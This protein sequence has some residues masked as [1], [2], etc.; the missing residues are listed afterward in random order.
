MPNRVPTISKTLRIR[1]IGRS[2]LILL[3]IKKYNK[4]KKVKKQDAKSPAGD[5]SIANALPSLSKSEKHE[6]N[7]D[8]K[9]LKAG[10][11]VEME[12]TGD[13]NKAKK[14]AM[15]HL[16]ED[17]DYYKDWDNKEKMLFKEKLGTNEPEPSKSR[18]GATMVD[19]AKAAGNVFGKK[20]EQ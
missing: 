3:V 4:G 11:K 19:Q 16:A 15:D 8:P 7:F 17:K 10:T 18:E 14:I 2:S 12:H 1:R 13:S 5:R 9:Q 20:I 6:E